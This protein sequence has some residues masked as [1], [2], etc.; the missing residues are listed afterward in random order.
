MLPRGAVENT[1]RTEVEEEEVDPQVFPGLLGL[2]GSPI[3]DAR[4]WEPGTN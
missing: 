3:A 2:E 4:V 1:A